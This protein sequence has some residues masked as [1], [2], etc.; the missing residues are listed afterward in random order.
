M[1]EPT[2]A[3]IATSPPMSKREDRM[4]MGAGLANGRRSHRRTLG[5]LAVLAAV[6]MVLIACA[7]TDSEGAPRHVFSVEEARE[8]RG[9]DVIRVRGSV[10][11][12]DRGTARLCSSLAESDPPQCNGPSMLVRRLDA[13][14]L[15]KP[16]HSGG[17]TWAERVTLRGTVHGGVLTLIR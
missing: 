17:V 6:Q 13:K 8:H 15:P 4:S 16:S 12:D 7:G 5:T 9:N 10:L 1:V 11:I 3:H 14:A 2:P